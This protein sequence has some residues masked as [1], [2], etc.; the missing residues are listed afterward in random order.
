MIEPPNAGAWQVNP[1]LETVEPSESAGAE[2]GSERTPN[3]LS[4][5]TPKNEAGS[6]GLPRSVAKDQEQVATGR[7][8]TPPVVEAA[9]SSAAASVDP[10]AATQ[11]VVVLQRDPAEPTRWTIENDCGAPVGVIVAACTQ[12]A[13]ACEA[14]GVTPWKYSYD[15]V[16][17]PNKARRT[18]TEAEQTVFGEHI[19]DAACIVAAPAAIE[20]IS[21]DAPA[22]ASDTWRANLS[23]AR[24][25][26]PCLMQ[27]LWFAERGRRTGLSPDV[28]RGQAARVSAR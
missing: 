10:W 6:D 17:L 4:A 23:I 27:L 19:R 1:L 22:R 20:L 18:I 11:C 24:E 16:L 3:R 12:T 26:D 13:V 8:L 7:N 14:A 15:E 2:A 25:T 9:V 21:M 5:R 28:L